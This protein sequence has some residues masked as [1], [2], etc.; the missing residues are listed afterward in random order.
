MIILISKNDRVRDA[1]TDA[2]GTVVGIHDGV[3]EVELD[4]GDQCNY[5]ESELYPDVNLE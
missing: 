3:I 1:I 5:F 2:P 4:N